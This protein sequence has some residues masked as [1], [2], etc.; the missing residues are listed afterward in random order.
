MTGANAGIVGANR[1][2]MR[3]EWFGRQ[4]LPALAGL[5]LFL[6]GGCTTLLYPSGPANPA[7]WQNRLPRLQNLDDWRLHGR[8]GVVTPG[9]GGSANVSWVQQGEEMSLSFSG[10]FGLGAVSLWGTPSE[11][12][13]RD[14]QGHVQTT[15]TPET[16]LERRLG[17]PI[18]VASLRYWVTGQ[19]AP[20]SPYQLRLDSRGLVIQLQ[21]QGWTVAYEAYA[22]AAGLLLPVRLAAS[23][24]GGHIK[25]VVND[26]KLPPTP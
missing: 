9:N 15:V 1:G 14:S 3:A 19:P 8:I 18:P 25:L 4:L 6:A 21:Q 23:R 12:Y 7:A 10:P 13:L 20:G 2:A 11:M 5:W 26:W 24:P 22:P 16:A 17:W